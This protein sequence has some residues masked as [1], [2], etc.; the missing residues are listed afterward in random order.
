M[1]ILAETDLEAVEI[2]EADI[3]FSTTRA[4]GAG[5]QNVNKV[6][7][8]VSQSGQGGGA[9]YVRRDARCVGL[10]VAD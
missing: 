5:G 6:R 9:S 10:D 1:P 4:G 3:E 2:P 7:H 8:A